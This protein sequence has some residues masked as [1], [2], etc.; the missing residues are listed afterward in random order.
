M[1][2]P[3]VVDQA[4]FLVWKDEAFGLWKQ[5]QMLHAAGSASNNLI[6]EIMNTYYLVNIVDNDYINGNIFTFLD[7]ALAKVS[8]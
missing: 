2:Q 7:C 3:T 1:W 6:Q 5:W 8:K 4:S